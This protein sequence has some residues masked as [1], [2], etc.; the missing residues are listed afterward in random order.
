MRDR[1][2]QLGMNERERERKR[3]VLRIQTPSWT[4][5]GCDTSQTRAYFGQ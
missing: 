2:R 3:R 5:H 1:D 4:D